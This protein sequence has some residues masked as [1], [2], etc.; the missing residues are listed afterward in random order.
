MHYWASSR[1][2]ATHETQ[3]HNRVGTRFKLKVHNDGRNE[4]FRSK[5]AVVLCENI[6][7]AKPLLKNTEVCTQELTHMQPLWHAS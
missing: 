3:P 6:S 2:S 1:E 5:T 7:K 4:N